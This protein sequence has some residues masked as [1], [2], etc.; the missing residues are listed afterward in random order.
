M[1]FKQGETWYE[2]SV[3]SDGKYHLGIVT[4]KEVK[5]ITDSLGRNKGVSIVFA[6]KNFVRGGKNEF[7][8]RERKAQTMYHRTASEAVSAALRS[9]FESLR[10][11]SPESRLLS[12]VYGE[13]SSIKIYAEEL[14]KVIRDLQDFQRLFA[15]AFKLDSETINGK[16]QENAA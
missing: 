6:A 10:K 16:G 14:P 2:C 5:H 1:T 3:W 7:S 11:E 13:N 12:A 15:V 9:L 8:L 4:I